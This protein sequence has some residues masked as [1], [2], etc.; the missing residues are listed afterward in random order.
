MT[1]HIV[2]LT[3]TLFICLCAALSNAEDRDFEAYLDGLV[4][5]QFNDYQLAGMTFALIHEGEVKLVKGYGVADIATA[6][7]VDANR[8]LFRPGSVFKAP[9]LDRCY[10]AG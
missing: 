3:L 8:H 1:K 9:D 5:A 2:L 4:A 7:P 6:E 10:A